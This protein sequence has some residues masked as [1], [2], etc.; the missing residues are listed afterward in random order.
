MSWWSAVRK[1]PA[2]WVLFSAICLILAFPPFPLGALAYLAFVPLLLLVEDKKRIFPYS[3]LTFLIWNWGVGYWIGFTAF[4]VEENEKLMAAATGVMANL[5]NPLLMSLPLMAYA[6]FRRWIKGTNLSPNRQLLLSGL[7]FVSYWLLFEF[8]HYHWDLSWSWYTLGN[9]LSYYVNYIQFYEWTGVLGGSLHILVV[10]FLLFAWVVKN[11]LQNVSENKWKAGIRHPLFLALLGLLLLPL[12]LSLLLL[13]PQRTIFKS[14]KSLT[15]RI[16]QP[17]IDPFLKYETL[18]PLEQVKLFVEMMNAPGKD[19]IDMV[20][21]PETAITRYLWRDKIRDTSES[22]LL[23]PL[24]NEIN[25]SKKVVLTGIVEARQYPPALKPPTITASEHKGGYY[26]MF[27]AATVLSP[28]LPT[29]T[30]EKGIFVPFVERVPFVDYLP[31][32]KKFLIEMSGGYGGYAKPEA[33]HPMQINKE[34]VVGTMICF[35]SAYG[36]YIRHLTK[37]GANFL[38]ILTND[39]WWRKTSGHIQHAQFTT[40]RAIENRRCIARSANTGISLFAD[41]QGRLH[42]QTPYWKR[43]HIDRT[44]P[45]YEGITF[46]VRFGDYL[47]YLAWWVAIGLSVWVVMARWRNKNEPTLP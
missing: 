26:D 34:A 38:A 35:E 14:D 33:I 39:G 44:I 2:L 15:V 42:Q 17:N 25:N 36:D 16:L 45:L 4:G 13:N 29:Q 9:S 20:L 18:T 41:A 23:V 3:Y 31:F 7:A 12:P 5:A 11:P 32:L 40:L 28:T 37:G 47:G 19:S 27:N 46:Y 8:L 6:R 21:L 22:K 43:L 10:N 30:F 1:R 24:W